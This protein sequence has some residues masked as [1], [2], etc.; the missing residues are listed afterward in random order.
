[1]TDRILLEIKE[2]LNKLNRMKQELTNPSRKHKQTLYKRIHRLEET[3]K[4]AASQINFF[5][6]TSHLI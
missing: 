3:L 5:S 6:K 4:K 2:E 1:M